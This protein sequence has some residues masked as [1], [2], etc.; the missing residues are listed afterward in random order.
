MHNIKQLN[1]KIIWI[2][3]RWD[4]QFVLCSG[5]DR[6]CPRWAT[7]LLGIIRPFI[8]FGYSRLFGG[9]KLLRF[10]F[11]SVNMLLV[12]L[13]SDLKVFDLCKHKQI[14][15]M[16]GS[17][18]QVIQIELWL[19]SWNW[20]IINKRTKVKYANKWVISRTNGLDSSIGRVWPSTGEKR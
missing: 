20:N 1:Y 7:W 12:S 3:S 16:R 4:W 2:L 5:S 17:P 8:I 13:S 11:D 19:S 14:V 6:H 9:R 18:K 10:V 15:K